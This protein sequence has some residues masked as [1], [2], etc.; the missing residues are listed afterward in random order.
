MVHIFKEFFFKR[1]VI[2][3]KV[4]RIKNKHSKKGLMNCWLSDH[5]HTHPQKQESPTLKIKVLE[6]LPGGPLVSG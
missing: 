5:S 6:G 3:Y 2:V 4:G 1:E